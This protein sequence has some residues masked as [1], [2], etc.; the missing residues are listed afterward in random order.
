MTA[1]VLF[2]MLYEMVVQSCGATCF[3]IFFKPFSKFK[4]GRLN[5]KV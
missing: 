2:I 4:V 3:L 1:Q 5:K